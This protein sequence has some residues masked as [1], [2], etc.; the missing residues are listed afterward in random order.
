MP[1]EH[2]HTKESL[3]E[4]SLYKELIRVSCYIGEIAMSVPQFQMCTNSSHIYDVFEKDSLLEG[5]VVMEQDTPV[6]TVMKTNF[7][8]KLSSK[9]GL[10]LYMGKRISLMMTKDPLIVDYFTPITEVSSLAM[11]RELNKLYDLVLVKKNGQFCGAVNI[12]NLLI[13]IAEEQVRIATNM[14]PLTGLP[15]NTLIKENLIAT[16]NDQPEF[17]VLYADLDQFKAY[18]DVYGFSKG[19]DLIRETANILNKSVL[20]NEKG[21]VGHIGG[22][23]FI[24]ILPHYQYHSV[25]NSIIQEFNLAIRKFFDEEDLANG[26]V[27]V[28]NRK[29]IMEKT[30]LTAISVAVVTNQ[31]RNFSSIEELSEEAARMKGIC[32]RSTESCYLSNNDRPTA[33]CEYGVGC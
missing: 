15:G 12:K 5:I 1:I 21:F 32:K 29:G 25:C 30:A 7:Y 18:N 16:L 26:Y 19:D 6:G 13:K 8:Q 20:L 2:S 11:G 23:D 3:I 17:S 24:A 4:V 31:N 27:M 10:A 14:N 9:Y 28:K 22:D 33:C